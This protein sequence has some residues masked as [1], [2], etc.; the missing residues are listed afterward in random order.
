[1]QDYADA[2]TA[3][4]EAHEQERELAALVTRLVGPAELE[5]APSPQVAILTVSA[6]SLPHFMLWRPLSSR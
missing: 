3:V 1:M 6:P 5:V 4:R 2:V